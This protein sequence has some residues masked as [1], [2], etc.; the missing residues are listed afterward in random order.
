MEAEG[1]LRRQLT[2]TFSLDG[3]TVS[4]PFLARIVLMLDAS[5]AVRADFYLFLPVLLDRA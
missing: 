1:G 3:S 2:H 5:A 4:F